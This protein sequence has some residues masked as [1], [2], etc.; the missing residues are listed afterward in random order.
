M[1]TIKDYDSSINIPKTLFLLKMQSL[2]T[3]MISKKKTIQR[4]YL[5]KINLPMSS[6]SKSR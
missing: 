2:Y 6:L 4:N 1:N 3:K 5:I